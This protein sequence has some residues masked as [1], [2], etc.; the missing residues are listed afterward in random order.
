M[1]IGGTTLIVAST[2]ATLTA[3]ARYR[4]D[5]TLTV[6]TVVPLATLRRIDRN[7]LIDA[8]RFDASAGGPTLAFMIDAH[9]HLWSYSPDDYPWIPPDS[10]LAADHLIDELETVADR[11]GVDQFVTVQARE[12]TVENTFLCNLADHC[13]RIA[14]IVGWVPLVRSD[15]AEDL[16]RFAQHPK[17]RGVRHVIQGEA[18]TSVWL[19]DAFGRGL[20]A[21]AR[22]GLRFDLLILAHQLPDAIRLA[23]AHPD[24]PMVL[25]H[26]AKPHITLRGDV[27]GGLKS[28]MD[29]DW[30]K[31]IRKLAERPHVSCKFS[32]LMTEVDRGDGGPSDVDG[33]ASKGRDDASKWAEWVR[34]FFDVAVDAFGWERLMYGSDWPVCKLADSYDVW[35]AATQI[36]TSD[37]SPDQRDRFYRRNAASAYAIKAV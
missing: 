6:S 2:A 12:S 17:A 14:A 15:V 8:G 18:D 7:L 13:E 21:V 25:D 29:T 27:A 28:V 3:A 35:L 10:P 23:D 5:A 20:D 24:L 19:G 34:P 1:A 30:E 4:I 11:T 37:I 22:A 36:L 31:N 32:A 9:H 33:D 26:V 16:D